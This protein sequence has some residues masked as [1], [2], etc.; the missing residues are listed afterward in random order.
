MIYYEVIAI[1]SGG[2]LMTGYIGQQL[3]KYRLLQLLGHGDF[4]DIYASEHIY[5]GTQVVIKVLHEQPGSQEAEQFRQEA[6][7]VAR[8]EHPHIIRVLDSGVEEA[9]PYIVLSYVP[10]STLRDR[11]PRGVILPLPTIVEYIRQLADAL[12]YAHNERIIHCN[13]KPENIFFGR[14]NELLLDD[15]GIARI[16]QRARSG[17][18]RDGADIAYMAPELIEGHVYAASDQYAL[19]ILAYEWLCGFCPFQGT[20]AEIARQHT[21]IPPPSLQGRLPG[22]PPAV[23]PVLFTALAKDPAERFASIQQFAQAF[24]Q[25]TRAASI[26]PVLPPRPSSTSADGSELSTAILA[27]VLLCFNLLPG[28]HLLR[29]QHRHRLPSLL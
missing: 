13:I 26:F 17:H 10:N 2:V 15:F 25:A 6:S 27:P 20:P 22:I 14:Q 7:R 5:M 1:A 16:S 21:M 3:G 8:L 18:I 12:Q 9:I 19:G 29:L 11:Y 24:E 23:E 4:A 28:H